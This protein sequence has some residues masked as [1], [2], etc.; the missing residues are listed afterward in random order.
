MGQLEDMAMFVRIVEAGSITKAAEQ[1]NIAKSAVSRRLKDLEARLGTQLIS[2][3][4]RH[5]HLTQAG[6]Q[7]YQQVNSISDGSAAFYVDHG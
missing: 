6:E 2:R 1:L 3:T 5:S 7:Y 4:T